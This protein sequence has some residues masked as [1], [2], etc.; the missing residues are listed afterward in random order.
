MAGSNISHKL[1]LSSI[2]PSDEGTYECRVIDFSDGADVRHHRVRAYLQV[3]P[4][5]NI[6]GDN[7]RG[8]NFEP[9]DD[10][11]KRGVGSVKV[12]DNI[13]LHANNE[14]GHR[15]QHNHGHH[16]EHSEQ[17]SP[18]HRGQHHKSTGEQRERDA[19]RSHSPSDCANEPSCV[20]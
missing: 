20:L 9:M 4:E 12:S 16:Q 11:T 18:A 6:G 5:S 2:K 3:A 13:D 1:R 8:A 14:P 10:T 19:E 7:H 17:S 15:Q